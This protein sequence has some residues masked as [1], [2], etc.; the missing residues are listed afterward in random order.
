[1]L[2]PHLARLPHLVR[3]YLHTDF[4]AW[5]PQNVMLLQPVRQPHLI[6]QPQVVNS[7]CPDCKNED[8]AS[9]YMVAS[10]DGAAL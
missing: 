8:A 5:Q 6:K 9:Q 10:Q 4:I 1:M 3:K 7:P 2:P